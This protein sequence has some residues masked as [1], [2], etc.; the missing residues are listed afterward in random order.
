MQPLRSSG[1]M[2][3]CTS[4]GDPMTTM[5]M[6]KLCYQGSADELCLNWLIAC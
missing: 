6:N 3:S 5:R 2:T 1:G 4:D